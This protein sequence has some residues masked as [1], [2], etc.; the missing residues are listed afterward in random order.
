[1]MRNISSSLPAFAT[2]SLDDTY[3]ASFCQHSCDSLSALAVE[4]GHLAGLEN[5]FSHSGVE[6]KYMLRLPRRFLGVCR[7]RVRVFDDA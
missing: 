2:R 6:C 3:G 4:T 7:V 5:V 1:M